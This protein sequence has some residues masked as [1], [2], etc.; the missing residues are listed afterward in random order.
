MLSEETPFGIR[1]DQA[2]KYSLAVSDGVDEITPEFSDNQILVMIPEGDALD[3]CR[4]DE[5]GLANSF[6]IDGDT[7][8]EI[9]IEKD[10]E[11]L[12]RPDD[13]DRDDAF[14][15]PAVNE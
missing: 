7:N 4:N 14:P 2:F 13:P 3:W 6:E 11:C 12:G 8:L 10:F 15:N 1:T 5:V 9:L